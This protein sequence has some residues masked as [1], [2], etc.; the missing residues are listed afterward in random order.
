[1]NAGIGVNPNEEEG[2]HEHPFHRIAT[3]IIRWIAFS[4]K[5][6]S[7]F[8]IVFMFFA[9]LANVVLRYAFGSGISWAYEIHALL[10][11]WLVGAGVVIAASRGTNIAITILP[12]LLAP[13]LRRGLLIVIE[14]A[15]LVICVTVLQ[16]S[17]PILMAS[18]FQTLSTLGIKQYWGYLS[19]VYAFAGMAV[20]SALEV[21]RLLL[22]RSVA[23][24]D[25]ER[26][27][28]S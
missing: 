8:T 3:Q 17:K 20:I 14:I 7:V 5:V 9:L 12:D 21:A 23:A 2:V 1:M 10:L 24:S 15:L 28:L 11:P 6:I 27:S 19:I 13:E 18:K 16:S 22:V 26:R 25:V 4:G